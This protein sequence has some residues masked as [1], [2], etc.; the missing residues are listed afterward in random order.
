MDE[1]P[2]EHLFA[3]FKVVAQNKFIKVF[4]GYFGSNP[5]PGLPE[6]LLNLSDC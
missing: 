1:V 5:L 4:E 2:T 6:P 3:L